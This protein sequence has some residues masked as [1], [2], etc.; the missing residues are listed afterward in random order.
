MKAGDVRVPLFLAIL[1]LSAVPLVTA[2][3]LLDRAL[4]TSLKLGFN[5][6]VVRALDEASQHLRTLGHMDSEHRDAYRAQFEELQRLKQVYSNPALIRGSIKDS[7]KIYFGS[8][9]IVMVLL[10]VLAAVLLSRRIARRYRVLFDELMRQREK[11]RY[12]QEMSSW[13]ELARMLAHEIKNPLTPIEV[14]VSSLSRSYLQKGEHEFRE[15]L[16]KTERMISEELAHLK[17]TVNRFSGF[18]RLP[19]VVAT[20]QNLTEMLT[21]QINVLANA[22]PEADLEFRSSAI[23]AR[24]RA[25]STLF[26]QVLANIVRNGIEANQDTRVRF[27]IELT[28]DDDQVRLTF[29]NDGVPVPSELASRIFDP[30]VSSKIGKNNMGLGLAIVR[31][32]MIEHGG[33]IAYVESAGQPTFVITMP[34]LA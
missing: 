28:A 17:N 14:L 21:H 6:Q 1:V 5:P 16:A 3:Y 29:A 33:D 34:R 9:F 31:K 32:I 23:D 7:L 15:Q 22:M 11:V 10:A 26:R 19:Q 20:E 18:A 4:D 13:Q 30:Y 12:L 2:F 25:D 27:A 8:G 24:V